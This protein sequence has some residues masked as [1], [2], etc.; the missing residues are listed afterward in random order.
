ME[1]MSTEATEI[2][3]GSDAP[4]VKT[5]AAN[6][7][8]ERDGGVAATDEQVTADEST[9]AEEGKASDPQKTIDKLL[10]RIQ[11]QS[12]KIGGTARERD[13]IAQENAQLKAQLAELR[14]ESGQT[15][16]SIE[17][18]AIR[19]ARELLRD[20]THAES[21]NKRAAAVLT[22]GKKLPGFDEARQALAEEVKLQD[23]G[24]PTALLEAI[25][26]MDHPAKIIHHLGTNL[27][28]AAEFE[29][30]SPIA[31]GRRLEKLENRLK[32]EG[33]V[34]T[35]GA[36]APIEPIKGSGGKVSPEIA[37]MDFKEYEKARAK[38]GASWARYRS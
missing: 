12:G 32:Q 10:R 28:E 18:A 29:G 6:V 11:R 35:S 3:T 15:Q 25:L 22:E 21:L 1:P 26:E 7:E 24:R 19:K 14:G 16:E 34:K 27:D 23:R 36:P 4:E 9:D 20:E 13:L 17:E 8:P 30:L 37:K 2:A 5:P 38:A 31:I 33:K